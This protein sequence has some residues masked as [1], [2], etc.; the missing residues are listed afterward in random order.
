MKEGL[1]NK[2][3]GMVL[4]STWMVSAFPPVEV[5]ITPT[6][7]GGG[8]G[9][10]SDPFSAPTADSFFNLI[11]G[12]PETGCTG[13]VRAVIPEN[14]T[15]H[16]MP[17]TFLV[18]EGVTCAGEQRFALTPRR[19]WKIRGAGMDAT[20]LKLIDQHPAGNSGN[21]KVV[22]IGGSAYG[23]RA[24]EAPVDMVEVSDLTVD[25]NLQ[26]QSVAHCTS[27]I[28]LRG[29]DN[30]VARVRAVNWGS[31]MPSGYECFVISV[32]PHSALRP[33]GYRN[34]I[35][36]DCLV[37]TPAPVRHTEG[38]TCLG[39]GLGYGSSVPVIDDLALGGWVIRGCTVRNITSG[40][41]VGQPR[42]VH[43][44][45]GG[46]RG[47]DIH[48]NFAVNLLGPEAVGSYIDSFDS[49]DIVYRD[50]NYL[51]VSAGI[52]YTIGRWSAT[53]LVF[54][55]NIITFTNNGSGISLLNIYPEEGKVMKAVRIAGNVIY[56]HVPGTSGRALNITGKIEFSADNNVI[57][58]GP[59]GYD[60]FTTGAWHSALKALSF[61]DNRN[62]RGKPLVIGEWTDSV[63][64][65]LNH[66]YDEQ[67]T[68]VPT[69]A[70]WYRV[71][72]SGGGTS[73]RLNIS[74]EDMTDVGLAFHEHIYN[75]THGGISQLYNNSWDG[76]GGIIAVRLARYATPGADE[77]AR[78]G[79]WSQRSVDLLIG[80]ALVGKR[81]SARIS[82]VF[83]PPAGLPAPAPYAGQMEPYLAQ[84]NPTDSVELALGP[85]IRTTGPLVSGSSGQQITDGTGSIL[86][87]ALG[88]VPPSH[89]GLGVDASTTPSMMVPYTTASGT[90][91][92]TRVSSY[93]LGLL[94]NADAG[95]A[96]YMF[97]LVPGVHV[98]PYRPRL[99]NLASISPSNGNLMLGNGSDWSSVKV[100]SD[101]SLDGTGRLTLNK[102][103]PGAFPIQGFT[104]Q[105]LVGGNIT[106]TPGSSRIQHLAASNGAS[107]V[108]LPNPAS[109]I[110]RE[111]VIHNVGTTGDL[112]L[113]N[114]SPVQ[115]QRLAP[116]WFTLAVAGPARWE[117]QTHAGNQP[118]TVTVANVDA[119]TV[120]SHTALVVP[121]G[122]SFIATAAAVE[123]LTKP[124]GNGSQAEVRIGTGA[125][126]T[127]LA[128]IVSATTLSS[129]ASSRS[130]QLL[131]IRQNA[132]VL[133]NGS[134][135]IFRVS[136]AATASG[137]NR[138]S[139]HI[140]GFYR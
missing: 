133:T 8:S 81:I 58:G 87:G 114:A 77:L 41:E 125:T 20:V 94:E 56:P 78:W 106:L 74:A 103:T 1:L 34:G 89:G 124:S 18:R 134:A 118:F 17:G 3:L 14:S 95:S 99:E 11:H 5:W 47:V 13:A 60:F 90:F 115:Q 27:A 104:S 64:L 28:S 38:T 73:A 40:S 15:I 109:V 72:L 22:I 52:L 136:T 69:N 57:D 24:W 100:F 96:Q 31:T 45:A 16:L 76:V 49:Q 51:N 67:I 98:Q 70:G 108:L 48:G 121:S 137:T 37:E 19:G 71:L 26:G 33:Q 128:S 36:E 2:V 105:G 80:G 30:R 75:P 132:L 85:G 62:L 39:V 43:G 35:I 84:A 140:T 126:S 119:R 110:G 91:G 82:G 83:R 42:F 139:A 66:H 129:S 93:S 23:G 65:M 130:Y 4:V 46:G 7:D 61:K 117:F 120:A 9:T 54:M 131:T 68:F 44:F 25:S 112:I 102:L 50:N 86:P 55:N 123:T 21:G 101:G 6:G 127:S 107:L 97:A 135:L 88:I 113:T 111:F 122:L 32:V 138:I 53:N 29:S 63:G 12:Q 116:G 59:S 79:F 92:F 10:E